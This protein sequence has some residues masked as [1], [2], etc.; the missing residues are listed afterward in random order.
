MEVEGIKLKDMILAIQKMDEIKEDAVS[1]KTNDEKIKALLFDSIVE[2]IALKKE[3][4][5]INLSLTDEY[6][7]E[8]IYSKANRLYDNFKLLKDKID[9]KKEQ[10]N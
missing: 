4:E 10:E 2:S 5:N 1:I 3:L 7:I 8:G 9:K 6:E